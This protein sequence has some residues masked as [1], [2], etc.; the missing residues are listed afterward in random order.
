MKWFN[1]E[2]LKNSSFFITPN[3]PIVT[4]QRYKFS[5]FRLAAYIGVYTL[6]AWLILIFILSITPLKDFL[7]VIDN[8]E[9]INQREKI[10]QL[11][12]RVEILTSQLG[13]MSSTNE[14][15]KY[16][17]RL[18]QKDSVKSNDPL[19]D[20]LRKPIN[21]KL[22]VGGDIYSALLD[23]IYGG[24]QSEEKSK[25][26]FLIE[27]VH[28]VIMEEFRSSKGHMGVDYG[29]KIG[30]PVYASA[31]GL[32]TFSDYTLDG[33]YT[34]MIQHDKNFITVYKHCSTLIKKVRDVV[35]QGEL[36]ALSGNSGKN[37][38]GPHLHFEIWQNGKPLDPQKILLK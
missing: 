28:G 31:G 15:I 4:T 5:I 13:A 12:N 36:I 37:T 9:L 19:Y 16:A 32:I 3:L 24:A 26:F 11:Q 10:Q 22:K 2:N 6:F 34:I 38:T 25:S 29:I 23:L 30:T 14:R 8:N 1:L 35:S 17:M 20:S 18:A 7:F 33:G 21:K 27:P